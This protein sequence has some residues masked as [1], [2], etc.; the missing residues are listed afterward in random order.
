MTTSKFSFVFKT[1]TTR[2]LT[3]IVL[4]PIVH[5]KISQT[6]Q[7]QSMAMETHTSLF[8]QV[9]LNKYSQFKS[10]SEYLIAVGGYEPYSNSQTELLSRSN[11][12]T[13][14]A[15]YPFGTE[16]KTDLQ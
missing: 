10:V 6:Y 1:L 15:E 3:K 9:G 13:T 7:A 2:Q 11:T 8:C 5:L 16:Y 14:E 12:W 4:L